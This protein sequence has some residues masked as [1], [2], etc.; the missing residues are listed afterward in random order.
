M[1]SCKYKSA[2]EL[3]MVLNVSEVAEYIG[4]SK[5]NAYE[6]TKRTDFPAFR[7]GKRV[8]I[9]RD[10]FLE[11]IDSQVEEKEDLFYMNPRCL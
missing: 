9:P 6:L 7:I 11:W 5:A 1:K 8:F 4:L 10:Q 2:E 3:P